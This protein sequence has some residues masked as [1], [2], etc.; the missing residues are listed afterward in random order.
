MSLNCIL[1]QLVVLGERKQKDMLTVGFSFFQLQYIF[2]CTE[3]CRA[4]EDC[5]GIFRNRRLNLLHV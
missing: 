2:S 3:C 5:V 4:R 1:V